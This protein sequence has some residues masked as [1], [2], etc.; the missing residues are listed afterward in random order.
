MPVLSSLEKILF[1]ADH[2]LAEARAAGAGPDEID[3][4]LGEITHLERQALR[5]RITN[6]AGAAAKLRILS[7]H[8]A[9]DCDPVVR[10]AV[11]DLALWATGTETDSTDD[12]YLDVAA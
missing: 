6:P 3:D 11:F 5:C 4:M 8:L 2:L 1:H 12:D 7:R 9:G 10:E